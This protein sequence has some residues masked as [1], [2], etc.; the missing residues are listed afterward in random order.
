MREHIK[1][2]YCTCEGAGT[3]TGCCLFMCEVCNGAEGS[4][5]TE[6]C[7]R[8]LSI[9]EDES[10]YSGKLDFVNGEWVSK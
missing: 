1:K 7:G 6:C 5:T 4:L 2:E 3:C 8:K 9:E 10:I